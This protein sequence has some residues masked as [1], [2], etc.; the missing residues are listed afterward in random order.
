MNRAAKD[1]IKASR[2]LRQGNPLSPFRFI[3][4]VDVLSMMVV[5]AEDR[6]SLEGFLVGKD[7]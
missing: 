5:R 7:R 3:I 4:V 6:G 1:W 2:G